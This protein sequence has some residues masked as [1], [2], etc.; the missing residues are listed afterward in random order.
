MA[1]SAPTMAQRHPPR[2]RDPR[3]R[4]PR[5]PPRRRESAWSSSA[6][7]V[8]V[9]AAARPR[10]GCTRAQLRGDR[11]RPDRRH[12]QQRQ[13]A[14]HGHGHGGSRRRE[15]GRQAGRCRSRRSTPP[16][17][18]SRSTRRRAQVAQ[19]QAQLAAED[20]NVPITLASNV[21]ALVVGPVRR[22]GRAGGALGRAQGRPAAHRAARAGR[23]PTTARRSSRRSAREKLARAGRRRAVG[24]RPAPQRAPPPS[25]A[26]VDAL[27]QSLAAARDRVAQQQ[28]Q[29]IALPEPLHRGEVERAAPGRD[30]QGVG[31][32]AAGGARRSRRRRRREAEKNLSYAKIVAPVTGIVAKK[33]IAVGD[34]VAPGQQIVA[35]A[36]TDDFWV[37]ANY[38]E[39]QLERMQ[40]GPAGDDPR[41]RA[42]RDAH[43]DASRASA[44]RPGSRLSVLPP[45]N[46]SGNYVKVVQR[47][48]VRIH[49]DPGQ[50]G[51]STGCA[52]G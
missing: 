19:A 11:R 4:R 38:R 46:A 3:H 37:T 7:G 26:N 49:L 17:C 10:T 41:R 6:G 21:S 43:R 35:I 23:R 25:A 24:L 31:R 18:R 51:R 22:R 16:T 33:S 29:I 27:R 42:R 48:P 45:E 34:H 28:A 15:P 39:T 1:T 52:S 30:P 32:R 20:P 14:H 12:H 9:V 47:I 40:P 36:Q 2:S 5:R 50:A 44:A 8:L 13:P